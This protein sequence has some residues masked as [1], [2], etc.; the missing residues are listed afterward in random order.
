[1][2]LKLARFGDCDFRPSTSSCSRSTRISAS[3]EART[4]NSERSQ[5]NIRI[6]HASIARCS[7]RLVE[8]RHTDEVLTRHSVFRDAAATLRGKDIDA[9]LR[10]MGRLAGPPWQ[11][12]HKLAA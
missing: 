4:S 11:A 9:F 8:L 6:S 2:L 5:S 10:A 12:K 7:S 1:M 3:R